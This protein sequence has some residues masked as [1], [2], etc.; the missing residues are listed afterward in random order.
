MDSELVLI[1]KVLSLQLVFNKGAAYGMFHNYPNLLSAFALTVIV[2]AFIFQ[3]HFAN[4]VWSKIGL[5]TIMMGAIGNVSDRIL[6]AKVTDMFNIHIIPVF[7][8]A[9]IL[10]NIGV[11][12]FIIDFIVTHNAEKERT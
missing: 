9:D 7:N 10:I 8:V 4:T 1:P 11:L 5:S 2:L 3:K 6:F 12:C